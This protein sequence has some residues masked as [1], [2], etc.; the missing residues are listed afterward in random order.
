LAGAK[1]PD[2]AAGQGPP[3]V[4]ARDV[5]DDLI[6]DI[7]A[8]FEPFS[9]IGQLAGGRDVIIKPNGVH[10]LPGQATDTA[11]LEALIR[12]LR[13]EGIRRI[14]LMENCT[15]GNLTRVVFAALKWDKLCKRYGVTP[16]YLDE[17]PTRPVSLP[18]EDK[19]VQIPQFL[20]Q[21]LIE[22]RDDNFYLNAPRLKTHSMSH[23][24]LGIK[25]QQGL[26][27]HADRM[28]DHN[29]KL[30][31]RLTRILGRFRPDFTLIEGITATI[32]GH[33]P[34][35]RDLEKS[36]IKT[37]LL[38]GSDDVVAADAAGARVFGYNSEEVEHIRLAAQA[39]LGC[40]DLERIN[41][42][43]SLDRFDQRYPYMPEI[44]IPG[45]VRMIYGKDM[46][47]YQGCRGNTETALHMFA[48]D[49]RGRGGFNVIMGKGIDKRE[50]KGLEGDFLVV[51]P[52]AA[53]ET[54]DYLKDKYPGRKIFIVPEHNDL[55]NMSGKL[56]RLMRPKITGMLPIPLW[57]TIYLT[58]KAARKGTTARIINPF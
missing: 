31:R 53:G 19:A 4:V 9:G 12:L 47:C 25:N 42:I 43:G 39:G 24:T 35:L 51:G 40:A 18:G 8:V 45:D 23:V 21:R 34:I 36:I 6:T 2:G 48:W 46:A 41:L 50:L 7:E 5:S 26:L 38:I 16:I 15:A 49:Y 13:R 3:R 37:G 30:A 27:I 55:A 56:A 22:K 17:G 10:F 57:R 29:Y 20:Y 11:F 32:Y 54:G 1:E 58:L 14:C 28:T 33:F 44:E 52:C